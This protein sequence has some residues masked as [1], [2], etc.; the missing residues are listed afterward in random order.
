[1]PPIIQEAFASSTWGQTGQ[2]LPGGGG[3]ARAPHVSTGQVCRMHTAVP[4]THVQSVHGST[5]NVVR[6]ALKCCP[7]MHDLFPETANQLIR[8]GYKE[9]DVLGKMVMW[10]DFN[11]IL[12][13][14]GIILS[15]VLYLHR[16]QHSPVGVCCWLS[17]QG[18]TGQARLAHDKEPWTHRQDRHGSSVMRTSR[19]SR[20]SCPFILQ[21]EIL[22]KSLLIGLDPVTLSSKNTSDHIET[23]ERLTVCI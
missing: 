1:M 2:H 11:N 20:T 15:M 7:I 14:R 8:L 18:S 22:T 21:P 3:S 5:R 12:N 4:F 10:W 23:F 13:L 16:G 6:W 17:W 19:P 9:T